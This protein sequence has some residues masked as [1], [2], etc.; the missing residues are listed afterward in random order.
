M[1]AKIKIWRREKSSNLKVEVV[2]TEEMIEINPDLQ[3]DEH[4]I[5]MFNCFIILKRIC[6]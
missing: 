1:D 6:T 2:K 3:N 4:R 5:K